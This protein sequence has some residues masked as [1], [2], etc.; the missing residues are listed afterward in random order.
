MCLPNG[1]S[2]RTRAAFRAGGNLPQVFH[3]GVAQ[4]DQP[5]HA[6]D[7]HRLQGRG[8]EVQLLDADIIDGLLLALGNARQ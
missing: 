3:H 1:A 5:A 4:R 7:L 2:F 6:M 8:S